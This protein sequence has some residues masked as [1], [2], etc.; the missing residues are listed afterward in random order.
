MSPPLWPVIT[1]NLP[2]SVQYG[3]RGGFAIGVSLRSSFA[4]AA[5]RFHQRSPGWN[6][7]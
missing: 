7:L 5:R 6:S 3:L 1:L 2:L 4:R